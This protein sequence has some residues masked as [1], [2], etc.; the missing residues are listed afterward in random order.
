MELCS[1][2]STERNQ[3]TALNKVLFS[4][5]TLLYLTI[6]T[7]FYLYFKQSKDIHI[8]Q[9]G[10][11]QQV[12]IPVGCIP[13]TCCPYLPACTAPGGCLLW[14][15][16][17]LGGVCS[18]GVYFPG[19]V[20]FMGM[21]ASRGCLLLGW[22]VCIPVFCGQNFW[23]TFLKILPCPNFVVGGNNWLSH[24]LTKHYIYFHWSCTQTFVIVFLD[25]R[26]SYHFLVKL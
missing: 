24:L 10:K 3:I 19:G 1:K 23:H 5:Y 14:G 18:V 7:Y 4:R 21:S 11:L 20:C 2:V 8:S 12:C 6:F 26:Y 22:G 13:P 17:L 15:C 16:L 25:S 9:M